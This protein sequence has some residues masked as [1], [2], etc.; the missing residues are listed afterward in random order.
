MALLFLARCVLDTANNGYYHLPFVLSLAAWEAVERRRPP[1]LT[2]IA[3]G[4]VWL[5]IG[6]VPNWVTPDVQ[7]AIYLAWTLPTLAVLA[8]ATFRRP[9]AISRSARTATTA[10]STPAAA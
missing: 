3:S 2:A 6:E 5:S 10:T 4:A 8:Y 9:Y 7:S 1:I